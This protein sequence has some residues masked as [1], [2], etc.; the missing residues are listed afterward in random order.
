MGMTRMMKRRPAGVVALRGDRVAAA[1]QGLAGALAPS[2]A[3]DTN[4]PAR[5]SSSAGRVISNESSA[6]PGAI[7]VRWRELG[8][9]GGLASTR[10]R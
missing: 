6:I 1:G 9:E 10:Q 2:T 5:K 8:D 4:W 7:S 3:I